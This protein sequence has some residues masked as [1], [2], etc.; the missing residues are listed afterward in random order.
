MKFLTDDSILLLGGGV[1]AILASLWQDTFP[2]LKV[3]AYGCPCVGPIDSEPVTSDSIVSVVSE[4]DPFSRLSLGHLADATSLLSK[5]CED[6]GLREL[7]LNNT[8]TEIE[9]LED[10]DL[11]WCMKT[12]DN[13]KKHMTAEK[14]YPPGRV[15]Y[16]RGDLFG[17]GSNIDDIR[18]DEVDS[19]ITFDA[20]R[21][22]PRMFDL[23]LHIPHR[24]EVLLSRIW[25]KYKH[26]KD[27]NER[28]AEY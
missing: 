25:E 2:G 27:R 11:R 16:M 12:M 24:Y 9:E 28:D 15:L 23:S 20:L 7:I 18:L 21:W 4:G 6:R 14:F 26:K 8:K 22:H 17:S 1:A 5:L 3:Y 13:L 19:S 10:N